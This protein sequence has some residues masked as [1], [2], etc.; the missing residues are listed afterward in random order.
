[1]SPERESATLFKFKLNS[2]PIW[3]CNYYFRIQIYYRYIDIYILMWNLNWIHFRNFEDTRYN[4]VYV[5][6]KRIFRMFAA[7]WEAFECHDS[8]L[9]VSFNM[10]PWS[11]GS[12]PPPLFQLRF[13]AHPRRLLP[14]G[15]EFHVNLCHVIRSVWI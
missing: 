9:E 3:T 6:I 2:W 8:V 5:D 11:P 14:S 7:P 13:V 10:R 4:N 15:L 1:M 12:L